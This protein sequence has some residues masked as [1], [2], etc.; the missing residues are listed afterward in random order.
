MVIVY[1][2]IVITFL[3]MKVLIL[4]LFNY[5]SLNM[6][7]SANVQRRTPLFHYIIIWLYVVLP[8]LITS[9]DR[10]IYIK[11]V[12]VNLLIGKKNYNYNQMCK[13]SFIKGLQYIELVV[14][15]H[16]K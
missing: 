3:S 9:L 2:L 16:L 15:K 7:T 8:T 12:R 5:E 1:C 14:C 11:S 6:L 10:H 4:A 13:P